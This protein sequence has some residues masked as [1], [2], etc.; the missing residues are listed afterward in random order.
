MMTIGA[1]AAPM[2][3]LGAQQSPTA[4]SATAALQRAP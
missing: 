3:V 2:A 1:I 4:K